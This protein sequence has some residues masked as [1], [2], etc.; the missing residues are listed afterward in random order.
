MTHDELL[1][2]QRDSAAEALAIMDAK[3]KDYAGAAG[4][5]PFRNFELCEFLGI[6]S[7]E[8]GILV[9]MC[10]KLARL[11]NYVNSGTL[12][13]KD[14]SRHDT[15]LDNSNYSTI[16]DAYCDGKEPKECTE[17]STSA[18]DTGTGQTSM[19]PP[20]TES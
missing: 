3:N 1:Q 5:T 9:R 11:A 10:D 7:T 8:V 2:F 6:C 16:L 18:E 19:A 15:C 12:H 4:D 17:S 20:A 13:V 14:E